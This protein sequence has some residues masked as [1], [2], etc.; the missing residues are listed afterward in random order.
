[1]AFNPQQARNNLGEWTKEPNTPATAS[2][3]TA[4]E[5]YELMDAAEQTEDGGIAFAFYDDRDEDDEPVNPQIA[6]IS[7]EDLYDLADH[8]HD[9]LLSHDVQDFDSPT[10]TCHPHHEHAGMYQATIS[11][12]HVLLDSDQLH[13]ITES[14]SSGCSTEWA[15]NNPELADEERRLRA[16]RLAE[17]A[18]LYDHGQAT[19]ERL[20]QVDAKYEQ[21]WEQARA[22][23]REG[24]G[25]KPSR[26]LAS[27]YDERIYEL[28]GHYDGYSTATLHNAANPR[29]QY[30][31]IADPYADDNPNDPEHMLSV[32]ADNAD[33][34]AVSVHSRAE[35]HDMLDRWQ[36]GGKDIT[37]RTMRRL[38]STLDRYV[39]YGSG[40]WKHTDIP[41]NIVHIDTDDLNG[42]IERFEQEGR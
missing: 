38:E 17:R 40:C 30:A 23:D 2:S 42:K 33:H 37:P 13:E 31:T 24:R 9:R 34:T 11:G 10:F 16:A 12:R 26:T 27:K 20:A 25:P 36:K 39:D 5:R 35:L 6:S 3:E 18:S 14:A 19:E 8:A 41:A 7:G 28:H 21:Q 32:H 22:A 29:Y 15:S 4:Y 1:M